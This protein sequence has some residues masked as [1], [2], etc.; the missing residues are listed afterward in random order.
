MG[1]TA[2]MIPFFT[3]DITIIPH[4]ATDAGLLNRPVSIRD[5]SDKSVALYRIEETGDYEVREVI[6]G[7]LPHYQRFMIGPEVEK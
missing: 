7:Q 5:F 3:D 6:P 1:T 2:T 4:T